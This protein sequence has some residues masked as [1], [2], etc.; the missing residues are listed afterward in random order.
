[1]LLEQPVS[2]R[3]A[4]AAKRYYI[5][6]CAMCCALTIV[7]VLTL[8]LLPGAVIAWAV[9]LLSWKRLSRDFDYEF[10][11][12]DISIF[13]VKGRKRKCRIDINVDKV[14]RICPYGQYKA[15]A[16]RKV[17]VEDYASGNSDARVYSII[18]RERDYMRHIIF[19][20]NNAILRGIKE[21]SSSPLK[22]TIRPEDME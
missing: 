2:R 15:P 9:V 7:G 10:Y 21:F 20:P 3:P 18:V 4:K 16:D 6:L 13:E 14:E 11:R 1:M 8:V 17:K 19:E 22:I 5:M 12:G